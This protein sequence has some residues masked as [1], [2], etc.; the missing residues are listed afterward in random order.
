MLRKPF[1]AVL[2]A[3]LFVAMFA[4]VALVSCGSSEEK[5]EE[6]TEVAAPAATDT[7]P[8]AKA[9]SAAKDSMDDA[10]TRP[11]VPPTKAN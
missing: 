10:S 7:V 4:T 6:T 1:K 5:K 11:V 2:P 3:M 8:T 9:D